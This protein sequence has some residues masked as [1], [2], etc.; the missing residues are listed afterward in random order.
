MTLGEKTNGLQAGGEYGPG[1]TVQRGPNGEARRVRPWAFR[2]SLFSISSSLLS[3]EISLMRVLRVEGFG[4]FSYTAIALALLG[5]GASG[6]LMFLFEK[7][8]TGREGTVLLFAPAVLALT[9]GGGFALSAAV[10][11]DPLRILWDKNQLIL[12]VLRFSLYTIPFAAGAAYILTAFRVESAGKTYFYNL[13]G[14]SF[15][16]LVLLASLFV[17]PPGRLFLVPMALCLIA[18]GL[19]LL[20]GSAG[21]GAPGPRQAALAILLA[22]IG[23][24][25]LFWGRVSILPYK[26]REVALNLPGARIVG[27]RNTPFGTLEVIE[28]A[29]L[30]YAP[31]LS[32]AYSGEL[33]EQYGIFLDGDRLAAIDRR[34]PST[35]RTPAGGRRGGPAKGGTDGPD[36]PGYLRFQTQFAAY[37]LYERPRVL[38]VGFGGGVPVERALAGGA[39]SIT[40]T[41]ENPHLVRLVEEITGADAFSK[42][43]GVRIARQGARRFL[44]RS[45]ETWDVVELALTDTGASSIGGVYSGGAAYAL[46]VEAFR[47]YLG[48]LADGG[49]LSVTA[50]IQN[51]PR[52]SLRLVATAKDALADRGAPRRPRRSAPGNTIGRSDPALCIVALRSWSTGTILV[53]NRPFQEREIERLKEFCRQNFFDMI[54]YPGVREGETNVYT[55]LEE[56]LYYKY[57][58]EILAARKLP[59]SSRPGGRSFLKSYIFDVRPPVDDRP[60]FFSFFKLA[61]APL[62]FRE[63]GT[64]WLPVIEG[65]IVVTFCTFLAA[66]FLSSLFI[67]IPSAFLKD[68]IGANRFKTF[69]YFG[70]IAVAYIFIEIALIERFGR[71]LANP[72]YSNSLI[73]A[74]LLLFSGVGSYCSDLLPLKGKKATF[75]A[76]WFLALYLAAF[77]L[78]SDGLYRRLA[79]VPMPLTMLLTA[80]FIAPLAFA[81]GFPFPGA[82]GSVKRRGGGALSWAWSV[83][84][85]FSVIA[86]AGAPLVTTRLGLTGAALI[87]VACYLTAAA[88]FPE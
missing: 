21:P 41:E 40:V 12:L 62:L 14:S 36:V 63:M 73:L 77:L 72:L 31:G 7:M 58:K 88:L 5:F 56:D 38:V 76:V 60:Y 8:L 39:R 47:G 64:R 2:F 26:G 86:S 35:N 42:Q 84:G 65:G 19:R 27:R 33:P 11:F 3:L 9:L 52:S 1:R 22:A 48:H 53:K 34:T 61:K 18:L 32:L 70:L 25:A 43:P 71:F 23:A 30:R 4:N 80:L 55:I 66:A 78:F 28:S 74:A 49:T 85:Y 59:V 83:N 13:A 79:A 15:G 6:T 29:M 82:I 51:P 50:F 16:I 24:A 17:L 54:Y 75:L 44:D 10:K 46:T 87:A 67:G 81:M 68:R 37:T 20:S 69:S 45:R 57:A